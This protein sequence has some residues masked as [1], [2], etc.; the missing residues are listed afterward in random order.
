MT[1]VKTAFLLVHSYRIWSRTPLQ[2]FKLANF[3]PHGE[4]NPGHYGLA[5][6]HEKK[7]DFH[8]N[9]YGNH[10]FSCETFQD[11]NL[12]MAAIMEKTYIWSNFGLFMEF[13]EVVGHGINTLL[14][15]MVMV[16]KIYTPHGSLDPHLLCSWGPK[17]YSGCK[18]RTPL[19]TMQ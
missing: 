17:T 3:G 1:A 18:S 11:Q 9:Y 13:Y 16:S 10:A 14:H 19:L 7:Y 4:S 15:S 5:K 6:S 12:Q 8:C 2:L